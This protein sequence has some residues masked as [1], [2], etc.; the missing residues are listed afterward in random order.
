MLMPAQMPG[1]TDIS[2]QVK[3]THTGF[4]RNRA[5]GIWSATMTVKNTSG[6]EI[7]GPVQVTLTNLTPGVGMANKNG[8]NNGDPYITISA[9]ALAPGASAKVSIEFTN[10]SN[11]FINFTPVTYS[12]GSL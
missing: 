12:G 8:I 5:T 2:S 9:E 1:A 6:A 7:P 10:P 3:I 4:G 11:G